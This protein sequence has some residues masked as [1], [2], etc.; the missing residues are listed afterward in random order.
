[1]K[2]TQNSELKSVELVRNIGLNRRKV[3]R[4]ECR[5]LSVLNKENIL[6][7]ENYSDSLICDNSDEGNI[8][9]Y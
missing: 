5:N 8:L 6:C 7:D 1:M 4:D 2:V 3:G 9:I